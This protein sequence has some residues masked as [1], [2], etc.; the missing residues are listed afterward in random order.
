MGY[1]SV[2]RGFKSGGFDQRR[3]AEGEEGE[4]DEETATNYEIGWKTSWGDRRLQFNGTLF[5]VDY[6]DFQS[7]TFDGSSL[8]VTNAGDL[9]SYGTELEL[10]FIPVANMTVGSAIGYNKAEYDSFDNAQCTVDQSFY[11]YYIV[12]GAQGGAPGTNS[13][14]SQDLAD[15]TLDNAPEWTVGSYIQYDRELGDSLLGIARLEHSY[16]DEFYLEQDLDPNLK[17]D[18]VNLFN[19]RLTLTNQSRDWEVALWGRNITDE[20]Y[21]QW[22]LDTPT[23]GGYSG[24]TAPE[25]TYGIT[26]RLHR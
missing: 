15:E 16:V 9:R 23:L 11:Q 3:L 26:L 4:F 18:S 5:L 6:E 13:A 1:A 21:Y 8:R 24:V 19:L 14:C 12:D 20:E 10:I 7:Q 22:G 17:N 25:A 2:S